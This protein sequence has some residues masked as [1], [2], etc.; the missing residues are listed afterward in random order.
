MAVLGG[1]PAAP[2]GDQTTSPDTDVRQ[3]PPTGRRENVRRSES[4][5]WL[6]LWL[7]LLVDIV[8]VLHFATTRRLL[9]LVIGATLT[10]LVGGFGLWRLR[11][12]V[13]PSR[14]R[15][16]LFVLN[17]VMV[18]LGAGLLAGIW[19]YGSSGPEY[20]AALPALTP[21]VPPSS[22]APATAGAPSSPVPNTG[23]RSAT[24]ARTPPVAAAG[25]YHPPAQRA[26]AQPP[27]VSSQPP[28]VA[29]QPAPPPAGGTSTSAGA[30]PA[31]GFTGTIHFQFPAPGSTLAT[32]QS[33][34]GSVTGWAAGVQVWLFVRP[35]R[36][37]LHIPVGPCQVAG[38]TW[39][40][41][42]V[43]LPGLPG[44]RE[45]LDVTVVPAGTAISSTLSTLPTALAHDST[46]VYK[47]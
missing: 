15:S 6:G 17:I 16:Q 20:P 11:N 28:P 1:S 31:A 3:E 37:I 27:A 42:N 5:Q 36:S 25:T 39:K 47:R 46:Q 7:A 24:A 29:R 30:P 33:V 8:G 32:G 21:K 18:A 10:T 23:S 45:Y 26:P 12:D 13:Q 41:T 35:E 38:T 44:T 9:I 34:S 19:V 40:C 14:T 43:Q 22:A 4:I 2:D